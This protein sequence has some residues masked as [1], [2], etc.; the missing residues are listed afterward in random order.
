VAVRA[1][2]AHHLPVLLR[3]LASLAASGLLLV[4][5]GA[6]SARADATVI[7]TSPSA[8][9]TVT[10]TIDQVQVSFLETIRADVS[11]IEVVGPD[12][13]RYDEGPARVL[14]NINLVQPVRPLEADGTYRVA[15]T[16]GLFADDVT[17]GEYT[18]TMASEDVEQETVVDAAPTATDPDQYVPGGTNEWLIIGAIAVVPI[19]L[20]SAFVVRGLR[21][22]QKLPAYRP[23]KGMDF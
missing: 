3:I 12:G 17:R 21:R 5:P 20:S 6:T 2:N 18:F 8:G 15:W 7:Q 23:D 16:A 4:G 10:E 1:R 11:S 9:S 19:L 14:L 22:E 13:A